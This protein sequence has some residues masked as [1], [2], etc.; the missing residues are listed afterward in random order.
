MI[1]ILFNSNETDFTTNGLGGL[2]DVISCLVYEDRNGMYELEMEYMVN[3]EHYSELANGMIIYC[4]P[5]YGAS[6]QPFRIYEITEYLDGTANIKAEHISYDLNYVPVKPFTATGMTNILS[7]ITE[8]SLETNRFSFTSNIT[9]SSLAFILNAPTSVR[10]CLGGDE[11]ESL[12]GAISMQSDEEPEFEWDKFNV[13]IWDHRGADNGV[14]IRYAKNLT[15]LTKTMNSVNLVNGC[16]AVWSTYDGSIVLYSDTQRN[17]L[18][19]PYPRT[20]IFD[21]SRYFDTEPT[22]SQLNQIA[23]EYINL[24]PLGPK[25][26]LKVSFVD[27]SSTEEYKDIS[28][29]EH[30]K[31]CDTVTVVTK[32][33]Y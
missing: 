4:I 8:N 22:K 28:N 23:Q 29:L 33:N 25:A 19:L 16:I 5:S 12:L 20:I 11:E 27:I 10:T 7:K 1:P 13:K 21:A 24:V 2:S 30:I 3:G 26:N 32:I 15:D 17:S 6:P 31:L 14:S 9:D 18:E